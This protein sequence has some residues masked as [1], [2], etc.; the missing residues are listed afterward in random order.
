MLVRRHT[1]GNDVTVTGRGTGKGGEL[2]GDNT[3]E[4]HTRRRGQESGMWKKRRG[5]EDTSSRGKSRLCTQTNHFLVDH[6]LS[7]IAQFP[8]HTYS[9]GPGYHIFFAGKEEETCADMISNVNCCNLHFE[10][11]E[12]VWHLT[13]AITLTALLP[14][15]G[16]S[17][18]PRKYSVR[19]TQAANVMQFFIE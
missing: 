8:S 3:R 2:T 13:V 16:V 11:K 12:H 7:L 19:K 14:I 10:E 9:P 4:T 1:R 17:S 5:R 18:F 15:H 6:S